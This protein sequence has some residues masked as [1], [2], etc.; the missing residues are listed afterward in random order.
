MMSASPR[1]RIHLHTDA[2]FFAGCENMVG[3]ILNSPQ[4]NREFDLSVSY[5]FSDLYEAGLAKRVSA[6]IEKFPLRLKVPVVR[7]SRLRYLNFIRYFLNYFFS[8]IQN[9]LLQIRV[10][11]NVKPDVLHINNGGFPGS[12]SCRTMVLAARIARVKKIVFVVNNMALDYSSPYRKIDWILDRFIVSSVNVFLTGS[13]A[14]NI[15]L[16]KALGVTDSKR[17]CIANAV[18]IR[19]V[20]ETPE[21]T[22]VRFGISNENSP[23]FGMVGLMTPR[24]GHRFLID[25]V[26]SMYED[27]FFR[28]NSPLFL[29]EGN[30]ESFKELIEYVSRLNLDSVIKFTGHEERIFEFYRILDFLIFPSLSDEDFPNVISEAMAAGVPVIASELSGA[31]EQVVAGT[32]GFLFKPGNQQDFQDKIYEVLLNPGLRA[33]MA[34]ASEARYALN[35]SASVIM[36]A[37]S[38]LYM[39]LLGENFET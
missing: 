27:E 16:T 39:E 34:V 22:R 33:S 2:D 13:I 18:A 31:S 7:D 25:S 9:V 21:Q 37:Y 11:K 4:I 26:A 20:L 8:L 6:N 36:N 3:V 10:L 29:I 38:N 28:K 35:Y 12:L 23:I 17:R 5:R 15:Q 19:E 14:A 24:K 30:R 1:R 32:T